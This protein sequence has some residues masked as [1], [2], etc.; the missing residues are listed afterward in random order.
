[1]MNLKFEIYFIMLYSAV[2]LYLIKFLP[3]EDSK[4]SSGRFKFFLW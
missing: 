4:S 1:M 2:V 3:L